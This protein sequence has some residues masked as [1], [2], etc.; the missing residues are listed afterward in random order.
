MLSAPNNSSTIPRFDPNVHMPNALWVGDLPASITK[1][2]L[3]RIFATLHRV[4]V[5]VDIK[6]RTANPDGSKWPY[7]VLS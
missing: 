5:H 4:V 7:P 2:E 1:H 6:I 3:L